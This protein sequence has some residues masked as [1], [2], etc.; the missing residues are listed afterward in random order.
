MNK[1]KKKKKKKKKEKKT[2]K[3]KKILTRGYEL[4]TVS[5]GVQECSLLRHDT[6]KLLWT[7]TNYFENKLP[8]I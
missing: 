4:K 8:S 7:I 6:M 1:K 5:A 2:K 3:R